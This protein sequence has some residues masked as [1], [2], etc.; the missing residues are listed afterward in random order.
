VEEKTSEVKRASKIY[1]NRLIKRARA[2]K[3]TVTEERVSKSK[4]TNQVE[5]A[6]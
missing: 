5:R 6:T 4:K 1:T 3:K 2:I